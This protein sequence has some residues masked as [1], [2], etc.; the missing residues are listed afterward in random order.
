MAKKQY[1]QEMFDHISPT[2]DKLNHILS[3]SIDKSWRKKAVRMIADRQPQQVLDIA[4]GTGDFSIALA[5]AGVPKVLGIDIS[6]G[7]MTIG[8][9][10]IEQQGLSDRIRFQQ[11]DSEAMSFAEASFDAVSVAFGI[12]NF[13]HRERALQEIYRVLRPGGILMV[14]ELSVPG[15]RILRGLY[16][17]YFLHVL[18]A[19]GKM[20]SHDP[21][22]YKYLPAS[23]LNFPSPETFGQMVRDAGF[24]RVESKALTFGLCRIFTGIKS[25]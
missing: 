19:V 14:L 9:A 2:Y 23:V 6:E 3:L 7:M 5:K 1:V 11:E 21:A 17:L 4:C 22:A 25:A 12:R 15:N 24:S 16:K 8:R 13:E 20:I 10:K 18:P